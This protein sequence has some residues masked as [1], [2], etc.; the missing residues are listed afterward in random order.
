MANNSAQ[1]NLGIKTSA[2][3]SGIDQV[4]KALQDIQNL[5]KTGKS[6][7]LDA[8]QIQQ[9]TSAAEDFSRALRSAY[10]VDLN[11]VNIGKFNKS[12][13]ESGRTMSSLHED[14]SQVGAV[15]EK[16]F[17]QMANQ[18][19]KT[20]QVVKQATGFVDSLVK[21]IGNSIR[22]QAINTALQKVTTGVS[23]AYNYIRR[24]DSSLNDIQ[25]VT[26]K[27]AASMSNFA[28]EANKA[29]QSLGAKTTDYTDA[30]LIYYQQGLS[31][32]DVKG[33]TDT[34]MKMANVLGTSA[35]EVSQYMTAIWNNFDNGSKSLEYYGDVITSLGAHTASSAEEIAQ[36]LEKFASV[37]ETTGLSYEYATAALATV[38]AETRQSADVVGTAFKT[39]F[40]RI[41][42]LE[43]GDEG[44]VSIGKYAEALDK[45]GIQVLDTNG[46]LKE[47]DAILNEM[48]SKWDS[49]SKS[50]QTA[51]AQNVG[52]TRQYPQ[53]IALMENWDKV[54]ENVQIA[55]EATGTLEDQQ[56]IYMEST[57]A[58]LKTMSAAW[59]NFYDSL[60]KP[61]T[62]NNFADTMTVLGNLATGFTDAV[63]GMGPILTMIGAKGLQT[64][65]TD[66]A[67]SLTVA[68]TNA[69]NF[70]NYQALMLNK[71]REL[72]ELYKDTSLLDS[73]KASTEAYK[74]TL[75][76]AMQLGEYEKNFTAEE[77]IKS[78]A[79]RDTTAA[80][81]MQKVAI[82]ELRDEM[83]GAKITEESSLEEQKNAK[84][85]ER[86]MDIFGAT[87]DDILTKA[88]D[89]VAKTEININKLNQAL[90]NA[91]TNLKRIED[92]S[93]LLEKMIDDSDKAR[94]VGFKVTQSIKDIVT[95]IRNSKG[96]LDSFENEL[97]AIFGEDFT[98]PENLKDMEDISFGL[99]QTED[100]AKKA[101]ASIKAFRELVESLGLTGSGLE[102]LYTQIKN[103]EKAEQDAHKALQEFLDTQNFK[104]GIQG[105]T[106]LA[107]GIG[108]LASGIMMIK[109]LGNIIEDDNL[110]TMEKTL[111][112]TTNLTMSTSML[113][114]AVQ[115]ITKGYQGF[116]TAILTAASAE[117]L[118][119]KIKE[120][121]RTLT[122]EEKNAILAQ[123]L[124]EKGLTGALHEQVSALLAV[125]V[126]GAPLWAVLGIAAAV[127]GTVT[128]AT[129]A[130]VKAYNA[131]ADAAKEAVA[132][133]EELK[134]KHEELKSSYD[135]LISSIEKYED[136][137]NAID[138]LSYGTEQWKNAIEETNEKAVELLNTYKNLK[139][140]R[141]K[142][143]IIHIIN[144]DEIKAAKKEALNLSNQVANV[145]NIVSNNAKLKSD[146]TNIRRNNNLSP[147]NLSAD[148]IDRIASGQETLRE[149]AES[150]A[151]RTNAG[152]IDG[153][154]EEIIN[155]FIDAVSKSKDIFDEYN[156]SL[157]QVETSNQLAAEEIANSA[158]STQEWF[159]DL[160]PSIQAQLV[161]IAADNINTNELIPEQ[162][163]Q[164]IKDR[165]AVQEEEGRLT[166][167][168]FGKNTDKLNEQDIREYAEANGYTTTSDL[169]Q[170]TKLEKEISFVEGKIS[171]AVIKAWLA[172]RDFV[173]QQNDQL[174]KQAYDKYKTL[175]EFGLTSLQKSPFTETEKELEE[176]E[177]RY[178]SIN[179]ILDNISN[180][181]NLS[182]EEYALLNKEGQSYF[183]KMA[184]GTYQ[185][186]GDA[187]ELENILQ[188]DKTKN[189]NEQ[190]DKADSV[191]NNEDNQ[192]YASY[193]NDLQKIDSASNIFGASY[194]DGTQL[195]TKDNG[196]FDSTKVQSRLDFLNN[197]GI[198]DKAT[199]ISYQEA[200]DKIASITDEKTLKINEN[201]ISEGA[202]ANTTEVLLEF[203]DVFNGFVANIIDANDALKE[204]Q[205]KRNEATQQDAFESDSFNTLNAK[206][207]EGK[208]S[209]EEADNAAYNVAM[210][211]AAKYGL[212]EDVIKN[213][214]E[215]LKY[216]NKELEKNKT[217]LYDTAIEQARN[218]KGTK[219]L[220]DIYDKFTTYAKKGVSDWKTFQDSIA[221]TEGINGLSDFTKKLRDGLADII[222]ADS[223]DITD[224]FLENN[225][226]KITDYIN[227]K[228]PELRE[229]IH[230]QLADAFLFEVALKDTPE[231]VKN[232]VQNLL[233]QINPEDLNIE[234]GANFRDDEFI[235]QINN[236]L[237]T[238]K[239]KMS[240]VEA[241]FE[242]LN[243]NPSFEPITKPLN[244]VETGANG[245]P[246]AVSEQQVIVGYRVAYNQTGY[247]QTGANGM[248]SDVA[249]EIDNHR[250]WDVVKKES[251]SGIDPKQD[252]S[253]GGGGSSK[254]DKKAANE[255]W[256]EF[257][258]NYDL[259]QA[260]DVADKKL[261]NL[262]KKSSKQSGKEL[263]ANLKEQNRLLDEQKASYEKLIAAKKE[264]M[265]TLQKEINQDEILQ[266]LG[267][268]ARVEFD[269]SGLITNYAEATKAAYEK[270]LLAYKMANGAEKDAIL[271]EYEHYKKLLKEYNV[272]L[273]EID[274]TELKIDDAEYEKIENN[275]K[276]WEAEIQLQLDL[277]NAQ[278]DWY[279][280][281]RKM[282]TDFRLQ[283]TN[284]YQ[285]TFG[286]VEQAESIAREIGINIGAMEDI[287]AEIDKF[288]AG[289]ESDMF[290][291]LSEAQTEMGNYLD[292]MMAAGEEL[293]DLA[294][295][296]W[297]IYIQII[298]EIAEQFED[299]IKKFERINESLEH[300]IKLTELLYG[301]D[302]YD[303]LSD[304]YE[305]KVYNDALELDSYRQQVAFW[306]KETQIAKQ[307]NGED[308][309]DYYKMYN[310]WQEAIANLESQIEK[311]IEDLQAQIESKIDGLFSNIEQALT[312]G[313][314]YQGILDEWDS[315]K[316]ANEGNYDE[317]ERIYQLQSLQNKWNELLKDNNTVK[318]QQKLAD[319][320]AYQL[321][322]LTNKATLTEKDIE[323]AEQ[324]LEVAKAQ[325]ALE[326]AQNAKQSMK[327]VRGTDGNWSYQYVADVD[328]VAKKQQEALDAQNEMYESSKESLAET[329]EDMMNMIKEYNEQL[330]ELYK[331]WYKEEDPTK[332]AALEAQIAGFQDRLASTAANSLDEIE[333]LSTQLGNSSS[334]LLYSL[335]NAGDLSGFTDETLDFVTKMLDEGVNSWSDFS[336]AASKSF[337][338]IA[339]DGLSLAEKLSGLFG[340]NTQLGQFFNDLSDASGINL[341]TGNNRIENQT[342]I[343][344]LSTILGATLTPAVEDLADL[345]TTYWNTVS[346]LTQ[347]AGYDFT[348]IDAAIEKNV[349]ATYALKDDT[350]AMVKKGTEYLTY[351][352]KL[353][354]TINAILGRMK[355]QMFAAGNSALNAMG[356]EGNL[357]EEAKANQNAMIAQANSIA[358][359][360]IAEMKKNGESKTA[361]DDLAINLL[362]N[363]GGNLSSGAVTSM[364]G[365]GTTS[366]P[367]SIN[368]EYDAYI[369]T[370]T[371]SIGNALQ[372]SVATMV[373]D[374][375]KSIIPSG[376]NSITN[377]NGNITYNVEANFP[378]AD[379]VSTIQEAILS[380]PNIVSQ[381]I[382]R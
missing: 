192:K 260:I 149:I 89:Q 342:L 105:V 269:E 33:R 142:N 1:F 299:I 250:I 26:E 107:S 262:K 186:I 16:A 176:I 156:Q 29:A 284:P 113:F 164:L 7:G 173:E 163:S 306:E 56:A 352:Q 168:L 280:F 313:W 256:E 136:A 4:K 285:A 282:N 88:P 174:Q 211:E 219:A 368:S 46:N 380:L 255:Y 162:Q 373:A 347:Y 259:N 154:R 240:E 224:G 362:R 51:L 221:K 204:A 122:Q 226:D 312:K 187:K 161:S 39:L 332:R 295:E 57:S 286:M 150:W 35:D 67:N 333:Y 93:P 377:N 64:F 341:S 243:L 288:M 3:L 261:K 166:D 42:D 346:E 325:A 38:T 92:E 73:S 11:T 138:D 355:P 353:T 95:E 37:A 45:V 200:I 273:D 17:L 141:D 129:Y 324:Q 15:G 316:S 263:A 86:N 318:V 218:E 20:G 189:I 376:V 181:L 281:L 378:N 307:L 335:Y 94:E 190:I 100:S 244:L 65:G 103:V 24:L 30:S 18:I 171:T 79:L 43:L 287:G 182:K 115:N 119:N 19:T 75:N 84:V 60:V 271:K 206:Y 12:L 55:T 82:Q 252:S 209:K 178:S 27:N 49:L 102:N 265:K 47:M 249:S 320:M 343:D 188:E 53:L 9:A 118:D 212:D 114:G 228:T 179:K 374:I 356:V 40:A 217:L 294:E 213:I 41:Q 319:V 207:A 133:T 309:E 229:N 109:N 198:L 292:Q 216:E 344:S 165:H 123:T 361:I 367:T 308:S 23:D 63:G 331:Q 145:N 298:D 289:G 266:K 230:N 147:Y 116:K 151:N 135:K 184:D 345:A 232:T 276:A 301:D 363:A 291:S 267:E 130:L 196:Y 68:R 148:E 254:S 314:G 185:L 296:A 143:G 327:L 83:M 140:T 274:D 2:D 6:F 78:D 231:D 28:K 300:N 370:L 283:Y 227:A 91:V 328:E 253:K 297:D 81:G 214:T 21:T 311:A 350:E 366:I 22:Y 258:E 215:A 117:A 90:G 340:D 13:L 205:D 381:Y 132:A 97:K 106:Q 358:N 66:I 191:L 364:P 336:S 125:D 330:A 175:N 32:S 139:Y 278:Q 236:M 279:E 120:V 302:S 134:S 241:I 158:L 70:N 44:S 339:V 194:Y 157:Q 321:E 25:I 59:E 155:N 348:N 74:E 99:N 268:E 34:T 58:H 172:N 349:N 195:V 239:L 131:D 326:D 50:Q 76:V 52:G 167:W 121:H 359:G 199:A 71:E 242:S 323:L 246:S 61:D 238:G 245:M 369:K 334:S 293:Y 197:A 375:T 275:F 69:I 354:A 272:V 72:Q 248:P 110:S 251:P 137:R 208:I 101:N 108:Q 382:N 77:K 124:A 98:I 304:L 337:N 146:N 62:I 126:A 329:L 170:D 96:D 177:K 360:Y 202:Y 159:N 14:M 153:S 48:G 87:A 220:V 338:T 322:T 237:E 85:S 112:I 31:D 233:N 371:S 257:D 234:V 277:E 127:I 152:A 54:K 357:Y 80:I 225:F 310:Y 169:Y 235:A 270:Y 210:K 183:A 317:I 222:N 180:N 379:D 372:T 193:Y 203:N 223:D 104:N 10:D 36:G 160:S 128:I 111:Q 303:K 290:H 315:V 305:A 144:L 201:A 5:N 365:L 264:K 8:A 247:S 351:M